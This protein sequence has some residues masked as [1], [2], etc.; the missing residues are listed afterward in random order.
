M[1]LHAVCGTSD[2]GFLS[3]CCC[4]SIVG[5]RLDPAPSFLRAAAFSPAA[6]AASCA[7]AAAAPCAAA[8]AASCADA[9]ATSCDP[10]PQLPLP[11]RAA[12][13]YPAAAAPICDLDPNPDPKLLV[14][15]LLQQPVRLLQQNPAT[16]TRPRPPAS[17]VL[18]H[19][20]RPRL[21]HPVRLLPLHPVRLLPL[22]PVR[23]LLLHA[24][25]MQQQQP[26]TPTPSFPCRGV[27][28]HPIRLLQH[29]LVTPTPTLTPSCLCGCCCKILRPRLDPDPQLPARLR[30]AAS[31]PAAAAVLR[32]AISAINNKSQGPVASEYRSVLSTAFSMRLFQCAQI[33]P[34][35]LFVLKKAHWS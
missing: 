16:P 34:M 7:A 3:G 19:S 8:A 32:S 27:L 31:S 2:P 11:W 24:T 28:Q 35:R 14:R 15:M 17:C 22:H 18:Q 1:N 30:A 25:R 20:V 26:L 12:A 9:A 4:S 23:L 6:A 5:P 13:S 21:R 33:A 10:D 29:Q